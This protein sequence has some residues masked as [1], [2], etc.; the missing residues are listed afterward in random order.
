MKTAARSSV[1]LMD[2]LIEG[3]KSLQHCVRPVP[4]IRECIV[5][6]KTVE[7]P[8]LQAVEHHLSH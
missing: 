1:C 4:Q 6:E 2:D 5:I 7:I 3:A 8:Q